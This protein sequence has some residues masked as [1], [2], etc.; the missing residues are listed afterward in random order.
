M[1]YLLLVLFICLQFLSYSNSVNVFQYSEIEDFGTDLSHQFEHFYDS[2]RTYDISKVRSDNDFEWNLFPADKNIYFKANSPV[3]WSR[4]S[5]LNNSDEE[6]EITFLFDQVSILDFQVFI[7]SV[8][9]DFGDIYTYSN[10][11]VKYRSPVWKM[12]LKK[13]EQKTIY[14]KMNNGRYYWNFVVKAFKYDQFF[15][16]VYGI[17][18][19]KMLFYGFMG[20]VLLMNLY[21]IIISRRKIVIFYMLYV[22][23][24]V[25]FQMSKDGFIKTLFFHDWTQFNLPI[26][27]MSVLGCVI[28][29]ICF[30]RLFLSSKRYVPRYDKWLHG[31][32]LFCSVWALLAMFPSLNNYLLP[33][34]SKVVGI[35]TLSVLIGSGILM[36]KGNRLNAISYF[37]GYLCITL[38]AFCLILI[39]NGIIEGGLWQYYILKIGAAIEITIF[40]IALVTYFVK[41]QED[42]RRKYFEDKAKLDRQVLVSEL[43]ALRSQMNPHF[44]FNTMNSIQNF[45]LVNDVDNSIRYISKFSNLMRRI[46]EYSRVGTISLTEEL[47][48]I[49]IYMELEALRFED[50]FEFSIQ[51]DPEIDQDEVE[52]PSMLIQPFIENAIWHGLM[53]LKDRKG[54]ITLSIS[55]KDDVLVCEIEDNGVGREYSQQLKNETS[56]HKKSLG[57][58]ITSERLDVLREMTGKDLS[59]VIIDLF[60]DDI[61]S[62]TK[63]VISIPQF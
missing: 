34:N 15:E 51:V 20:L 19:W 32:M 23:S 48:S 1:K 21:M 44:A 24:L 11:P 42:S 27:T 8:Q 55:L 46:L 6:Q 54:K 22:L 63:V 59:Y 47:E 30:F 3:V 49:K 9:Y 60:H 58:Q 14:V 56:Q 61:A 43:N 36:K 7:D 28:F 26:T 45:L 52:L 40:T 53:H 39:Y 62:G 18:L 12:S 57:I 16:H 13:G 29:N 17:D 10:Y 50:Q 5:I 2:S 31:Y 41:E 35:G 4:L 33:H 37:V 38:T 25:V